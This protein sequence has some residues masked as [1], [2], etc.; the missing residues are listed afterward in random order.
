M[1]IFKSVFCGRGTVV[2]DGVEFS[3]SSVSIVGDKVIV[4]GE[5][6]GG[7]LVGAV[8]VIVNGNVDQLTLSSGTLHIDGSCGDV[9]TASGDIRCGD[10]S[11]DVSTASG[12]VTCGNIRGNVRT[13]SGDIIGRRR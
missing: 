7:S 6:Q 2:I 11:G 13:M 9:K 3:G 1:K 10:V 8:S 4:D 12:D 5:V